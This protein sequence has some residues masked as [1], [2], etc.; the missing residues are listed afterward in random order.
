MNDYVAAIL[1]FLPAGLANSTPV[2]VNMI[3]ALAKWTTPL[4][5]GKSWRGK[6]IFGT[7]KTWRGL[8]AGS[9]IGGISAV[10]IG[11]LNPNV[12]GPYNQFVAGLL[13][14][15]GAL[16]GDAI[17]SF[18]KRQRGVKPGYT[19]FP[20]DQIDYIVGG[21]LAI[22]ILTPIPLWVVG[23]VFFVYFILHLTTVYVFY[24]LGVRDRPI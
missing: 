3:P 22:R 16:A 15:F 6:R 11:M 8:V 14:G 2:V 5:F 4:D 1:F 21:L 7:N 20:F 12:L 18:F 24:K 17:E 23:T 13:L 10:L 19:W 9:L